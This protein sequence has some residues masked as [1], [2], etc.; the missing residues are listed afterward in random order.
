VV[1]A[2]DP[3][4]NRLMWLHAE[5]GLRL[6]Y[7]RPFTGAGFQPDRPVLIEA[8]AYS[9]TVRESGRPLVHYEGL[10]LVPEHRHYG[11]R[12]LAPLAGFE[13]T[14]VPERLPAFVPPVVIEELRP[15]EQA[16]IEP[17][18]MLA[19]LFL[20]VIVALDEVIDPRR[21]RLSAPQG[22]A[23]GTSLE[24]L[25]PLNRNAVVGGPVLVTSIDREA[26]YT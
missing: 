4:N 26:G 25:N 16:A 12:V 23:P 17:S 6:P 19:P 7:D 1:S 10:T 5:P 9:L 22:V 18:F 2:V 15:V 8:V 21:L 3:E 20:G 13:E 11:P 14:G 24:F